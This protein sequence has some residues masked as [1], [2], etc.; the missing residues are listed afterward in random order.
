[1]TGPA[2]ITGADGQLGRILAAS[3]ASRGQTTALG[4]SELDL[5]DPGRIAA[6]LASLR[7][8]LILNC[9]AFNDVDGAEEQPV[10]AFTINAL[11]VRSLARAAAQYGATLVHYGT[12]FVF[13]GRAARP[14]TE[15]DRPSP[16]STYAASK[17]VGE[18]FAAGVPRWYVLRVESLFGVA[19]SPG[20]RRVGSIDRI[21]DAIERRQP[22]KAFRDRIVSPSYLIDVAA[23]TV[24][25]L[26][27]EAPSGLYHV[28][29][30][31]HCTWYEF[32]LE[33][34][35]Q[36]GNT[37]T[38]EGIE[39][40]ALALRA[41]RPQFAALSNARLAETAYV[42]PTWQDALT[43]YLAFRRDR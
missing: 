38:I 7:P 34:G 2:L 41:A 12:D 15:A 32:A 1:M 35:R 25:L 28:V 37:D 17:L 13:D 26:D 36:L 39:T 33:A 3:F 42:M 18:W 31:G 22:V 4:R 6:T 11:A 23:A 20:S 19:H 14:Y 8:A 27:R 40:T 10:A 5:S 43:R 21:L 24:A 16:Q 29:N 9:A 30:S